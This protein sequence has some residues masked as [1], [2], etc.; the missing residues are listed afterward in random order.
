MRESG[1]KKFKTINLGI[2]MKSFSFRDEQQIHALMGV[3]ML[4]CRKTSTGVEYI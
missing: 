2:S 4:G 1:I 3:G